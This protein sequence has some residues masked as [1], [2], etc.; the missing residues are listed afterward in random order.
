MNFPE[1]LPF[2]EALASREARSILATLGRTVDLDRLPA[3]IRMRSMFSAAVTNARHLQLID[4]LVVEV[5]EGRLSLAD[6]KMRIGEFLK[7]AGFSPDPSRPRDLKNF[8]SDARREMQIRMNTELMQGQGR[9][10]RDQDPDLLDAFPAQELVRFESRDEERDW[11]AIWVRNGGRLINGRMVA[12][13]NDG[14]WERISRFGYPF[15]PFDFNS[16]MGLRDVTREEAMALGLIDLNTRVEP[17]ERAARIND[18][19]ELDAGVRNERLRSAL[20][21]TGLGEF[22]GDIFVFKPREAA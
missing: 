13:K 9:W 16:G 2:T 11:Q 1:P 20:E 17:D 15:P 3:A 7:R 10:I 22:V 8:F 19:L 12:L 4:D 6:A 18:D 21:E 5:L 14:I